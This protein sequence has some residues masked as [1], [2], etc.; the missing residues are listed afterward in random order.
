MIDHKRIRQ[1]KACSWVG[2]SRNVL[3]EPAVI[4]DKDKML[5]GRI[6]QLARRH[7]HWGVA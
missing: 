1:H 6:E 4:K 3:A 5:A 2:L 7:K